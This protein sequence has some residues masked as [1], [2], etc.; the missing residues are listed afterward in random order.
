MDNENDD[1]VDDATAAPAA[2]APRLVSQSVPFASLAATPAPA[3]V[4][5][6]P[7]V[8]ETPSHNLAYLQA[9]QKTLDQTQAELTQQQDA[10]DK[11]KKELAAAI[12]AAEKA[13]KADNSKRLQEL[14]AGLSD[15]DV[16]A[17]VAAR[18]NRLSAPVPAHAPDTTTIA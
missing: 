17:L 5:A 1:S 4:P 2:P 16:D 8:P 7:V 15:E 13:A 6:P 12:S 14:L 11:Q 3:P 9:Q 18:V 10:I